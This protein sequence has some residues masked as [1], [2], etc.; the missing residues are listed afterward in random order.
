MNCST[1]I[2]AEYHV[3]SALYGTQTPTSDVDISG[4]FVAKQEYYIGLKTMEEYDCSRIEKDSAG[5]NTSS[6]VDIKY[7]DIRKFV[8]LA[9]DNN[10]NILEQLFV[11]DTH[12]TQTSVWY[13]R[14]RH[15]RKNFVSK[16]LIPRF[17]GYAS[18]QRHKMVI[19]KENFEALGQIGRFFTQCDPGSL[20][21]EI[22]DEL[23]FFHRGRP[24]AIWDSKNGVLRVGDLCIEKHVTIKRALKIIQDRLSKATNRK[25]LLT[26]FGYDT[27]FAS[28]LIRLLLEAEELLR[29]GTL[30]FPLQYA[31]R[32]LEIRAGKWEMSDVLAEAEAIEQN[33]GDGAWSSLRSRPD[34]E[35]ANEFVQQVIRIEA[36]IN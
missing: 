5:R 8:R 22:K 30:I 23:P 25:D 16:L 20:I 35:W 12:V 27:K 26:K 29:T 31:S 10:P 34:F 18:A 4:I 32:I 2:L 15:W 7:Y 11:P 13:D 3:G 9:L 36:I 17:V 33:I 21:A 1:K 19:K 24:S 28:H 6:A 14:L